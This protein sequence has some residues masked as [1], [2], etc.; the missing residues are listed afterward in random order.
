MG[1]WILNDSHLSHVPGTAPLADV[2]VTNN[3]RNS[4]D[5]T[6]YSQV[7]FA[8]IVANLLQLRHGSGKDKDIILIPQ[9]SAS[10]RDPLNL[11]LWRKDFMFFIFAA[12]S[13]VI[14]AWSLMLA[15]GYGVIAAEFQ[16][17][18]PY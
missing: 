8:D 16:I 18:P 3:N 15:P 12:N 10:P 7:L 11:P 4:V 13:A 14:G 2:A 17:V 6:I 9:P 5:S 1:F